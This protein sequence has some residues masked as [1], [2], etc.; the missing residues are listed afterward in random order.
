MPLPAAKSEAPTAAVGTS[1]RTV[2]MSA[3]RIPRLPGQRPMRPTVGARR[4]ARSSHSANSE[5][6]SPN[7]ARRM[8]ISRVMLPMEAI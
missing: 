2:R 5:K 4:G 6:N 7:A 3:R 8:N 1:T